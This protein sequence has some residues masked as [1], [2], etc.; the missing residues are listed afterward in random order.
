MRTVLRSVYSVWLLLVVFTWSDSYLHVVL[1]V[2][3]YF[4]LYVHLFI[5][6]HVTLYVYSNIA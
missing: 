6:F 4:W 3:V 1:T 5:T 2:K